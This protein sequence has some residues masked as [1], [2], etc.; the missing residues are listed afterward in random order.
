MLT[1]LTKPN[2]KLDKLEV[3]I[4]I[5]NEKKIIGSTTKTGFIIGKKPAV[6]FQEAPLYSV[7]QNCY[8]EIQKSKADK[9]YTAK[10]SAV[11]LQFTKFYIFN[12]G[13]RPVFYE[14]SDIAKQILPP[15]EHWRIVDLDISDRNQ[16]TDWTHEREWRLPGDL[17]FEYEHT[18]I[19][20]PSKP[21]FNRIYDELD[22]QIV[23]SIAGIT[24]L[25]QVFA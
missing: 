21:M 4:K 12:K 7:A 9:S 23:K 11:G 8:Y 2:D 25:N 22:P 6:C 19:V 13:G 3:L 17:I 14:K 16:F 20:L 1:H 18:Y 5:L 15:D 10:Y 24:V